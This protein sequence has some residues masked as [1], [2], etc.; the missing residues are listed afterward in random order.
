MAEAKAK[1]DATRITILVII[2]MFFISSFGLSGMV[3][4]DQFI[5]KDNTANNAD[6]QTAD[7]T[8]PKE[9]AL[10]GTKLENFTPVAKVDKLQ[11]IDLKKG[12]GDTVKP[13]DTVTAHYTGALANDGTIFQSSHDTGQPIAFPLNG[14]IKGWQDGVPGM[15][16]GGKR[17]LLIPASEAYGSQAQPGIP[18]NSDLVFDIELV[19]IGQ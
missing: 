14:V 11:I 10:Q 8:K 12:T 2:V 4:W 15:Q 13:N 9:G 5:K 17:R 6:S 19:K 1:W 7:Q 16:V 3:I 18:A